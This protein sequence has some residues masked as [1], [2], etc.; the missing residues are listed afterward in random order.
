[1][2]KISD[3][4]FELEKAI[5]GAYIRHGEDG[6][7]VQWTLEFDAKEKLVDDMFWKPHIIPHFL[8]VE[9][10]SIEGLS[11]TSMRL[12]DSGGYDEPMFLLYV[13]EHEAIRGVQLI[14]REWDKEKINFTLKGVANVGASEV[15][16]ENLPM[17]ISLMLPFSGV[18]VDDNNVEMAIERLS[19]FF[20]LDDFIVP[21]GQGH[22]HGVHFRFA[23]R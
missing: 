21:A 9:I 3:Q 1:M 12:D 5:F 4:V 17:E 22:D 23:G 13:F 18:T 2:L 19:K 11:N 6:D 8:S 20:R 10:P 14:F 7:S 16:A 15:Y